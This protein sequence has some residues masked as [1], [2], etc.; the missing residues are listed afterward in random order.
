MFLLL[1]LMWVVS[2]STDFQL[3]IEYE[4]KTAGYWSLHKCKQKV[5]KK[6]LR[7]VKLIIVDEISMVSSLN[8]AYMH[9]RLEELFGRDE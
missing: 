2:P 6:K 4:G 8:I 7:D 5:M 3:P 9:L 1:P